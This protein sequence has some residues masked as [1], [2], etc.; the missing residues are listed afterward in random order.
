MPFKVLWN[1]VDEAHNPKRADAASAATSLATTGP[2][3]FPTSQ[4]SG[5]PP[6]TAPYKQGVCGIHVKQ[7]TVAGDP[8]GEYELEVL[9]TDNGKAQIGYN[10]P[11]QV[12]ASHPLDFQSK[13]EDVLVCVPESQNDYIAFALGAQQWPSNGN[14]A[15]GAVPGCSVGGWDGDTLVRP[16]CLAK[17]L[18]ITLLAYSIDGLHLFMYVGRW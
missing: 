17:N 12:N 8:G 9:M 10:R 6:A 4:T 2:A 13:L 14:F 1:E 15:S 7:T 3:P 16:H 5:P 18:L 11:I